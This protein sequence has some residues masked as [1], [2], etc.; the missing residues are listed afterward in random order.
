VSTGGTLLVG[1]RGCSGCVRLAYWIRVGAPRPLWRESHCSSRGSL[2]REVI[3]G[4]QRSSEV[5]R[6]HQRSSEIIRDNQRSSE[7]A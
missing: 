5:I 2:R 1:V 6:G 3:R 4:H 7:E